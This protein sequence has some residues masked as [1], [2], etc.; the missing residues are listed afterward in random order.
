[1]TRTK[2][3]YLDT[4]LRFRLGKSLDEY[5][6]KKGATFKNW[7]EAGQYFA[8]LIQCPQLTQQ[9]ISTALNQIGHKDYPLVKPGKTNS[10]METVFRKIHEL[11]ETIVKM[12]ARIDALEELMK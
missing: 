12:Q 10:I 7:E 6:A 4:K 5:I 1:M 9:N 2:A 3:N 8:N 11:Q